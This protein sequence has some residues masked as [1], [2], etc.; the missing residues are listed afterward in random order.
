MPTITDQDLTAIANAT[1]GW[2]DFENAT[3]LKNNSGRTFNPARGNESGDY[4]E[5]L[6]NAVAAVDAAREAVPHLAG[7]ITVARA[8]FQTKSGRVGWRP[9]LVVYTQGREAAMQ[10]R[11]PA[12]VQS[13][14]APAADATFNQ[15][16]AMMAQM[17]SA[18]AALTGTKTE[19]APV[20]TASPVLPPPLPEESATYG[21]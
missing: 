6:R 3:F 2:F 18:L 5:V 7:Q 1:N 8:A 14:P 10:A 19:T 15:M 16:A 4:V 13:A 11:Q 9:S 17:T 12:A 20:E 21:G